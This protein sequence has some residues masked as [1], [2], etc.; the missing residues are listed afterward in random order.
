MSATNSI[1]VTLGCDPQT[2]V[3]ISETDT[4]TL[5]IIVASADP[6]MP[7]DLDGVFF[8]LS[9]DST[10]DSLNFFPD[11]NTGSIYSPVTGVQAAVDGVN[12]LA[13]GAQVADSYDVGIQFGTVASSTG[14]VVNQANFTLFSDNGPMSLSD[15]DINSFATV[16]DSDGGNGQVLTVGDAADAD[17]VL[18]SKEVLFDNFNDI[19]TADQSSVVEGQTNWVAAWDKLVTNS[20]NEGVLALKTVSTDGPATLSFDANVHNTMLFENSGTM[21]DSLRVEVSIDGGQ[22]VLLDEFRVNDQGTAIVGSETG[23]T[24]GNSASSIM[25]EGGVLDTAEDTVQFRFISDVTASDEFIKLDNVSVTVS[26]EVDGDVTTTLVENEISDDFNDISYAE[27]SNV[28]E[29][30]TNWVAA[31]DKLVTNSNYEGEMRFTEVATDG[32]VSLTMDLMTHNTAVFEN[33]GAM[34]DSFRVEVSIDGGDWVLLDNYQVNDYG[35]AIV[36][37]ET[38]QSF[39][40]SLSTVTYS[41]GIL[42]TAEESAQFRVVSDLTAA[43]EYIKIDNVSITSN[44]EVVSDAEGGEKVLLSEDFDTVYDP[45]ASS[46]INSDAGWDVQ[47]DALRTDGC[48]DGILETATVQADGDT[49]FSFDASTDCA[50]VFEATGYYADSMSLQV[51]TA[52]NTWQTLDNFVVNDQGTALV[53]SETG[54]EIGKD[55]STLTYSGGA[56]DDVQGDLQFRFVSDFSASDEVVRLDNFEITQTVEEEVDPA[57]GKGGQYDVEYIAGIPVLQPVAEDQLKAEI[58]AVDEEEDLVI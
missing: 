13:N 20:D 52:D 17:P 51:R 47:H 30:Q 4:G 27:Q 56:L 40:N 55:A 16:V 26:E 36:G 7:V 32:P 22:W 31:W 34:E 15:L 25:Y 9:D 23:Q 33:S 12:T 35:T 43:D 58:N 1:S 14:G 38:G 29:G 42:D 46:A 57:D 24:F 18:V 11:A 45:A 3:T 37:S 21:A 53:G 39:G 2:T 48:N 41:G 50:A 6:T 10:L 5:F 8:N 44:E 49:S 28:V 54:N 19:H